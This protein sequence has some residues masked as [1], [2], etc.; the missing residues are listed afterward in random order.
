M[1]TTRLKLGRFSMGIGD[2]FGLEGRAQLRAMKKALEHGVEVIPVWNK[3]NREHTI[4]GTEP[5][6]VRTEADEAVQAEGWT[7]PYFVD[8]DHISLKTVDRFLHACNFFTLDV[9]DYIGKP[10]S[11]EETKK[12]I[13][14][15]QPVLGTLRHPAFDSEINLTHVDLERFAQKYLLGL[16]EAVKIYEYLREKKGEGNFITEVSVDEATQPQTPPELYLFLAGLAHY[17]VQ[18][19]TVAPKFSGEFLKGIDYVG[20]V[21]AFSREFR[22][23]IGV[24]DIAKEKFG[25]PEELKLSVH[26]GSDKFSLYPYIYQHLTQYNAGVHLKTAGTTWLEEVVGLAVDTRGLAI[27]KKIYDQ[28]YNR[29]EELRK[30]Y[31]TVVDINVTNLPSPSVVATW[32]SDEFVATLKHDTKNPKFNKDFRQLIHISFRIA[33]EMGAE[34]ISALHAAR[35][36]IEEHVTENLYVRHIKP[37]FLGG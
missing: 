21:N 35:H 36:I 19:Q 15:M 27:A 22:S 3:S 5:S 29:I 6:S 28:A 30:P 33:A 31:E 12:F 20:D 11:D 14:L 4:I 7:L 37:L 23:D 2:R 13:E 18:V 10:A 32:S 24:I 16:L 25:L 34:Y 1:A 17:G 26:S 9:A 8:A